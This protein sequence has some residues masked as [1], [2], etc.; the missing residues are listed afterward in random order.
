M[1]KIVSQNPG[2]TEVQ[3]PLIAG[4]S[5]GLSKISEILNLK[6]A[7]FTDLKLTPVPI[8]EADKNRIYEAPQN[9]LWLNNPPIIVKKNHNIITPSSDS[10]EIDYVG[11]SISFNKNLL[12]SDNIT[13]TGSYIV[14]DS[15]ALDTITKTLSTLQVN[16]ERYKGSFDQLSDLQ[17]QYPVGA[18]GDIALVVSPNFEIFGWNNTE[19]KWETTQSIEDLSNYYTKPEADALYNKKEPTINPKGSAT[20][21]DNFYYGGRKTWQN[22]NEKV[23]NTQL[24]GLNKLSTSEITENDT[25]LQALGKLQAQTKVVENKH[26][27]SGNSEPTTSTVGTIGQRYVNTSNGDSFRCISINGSQYKWVKEMSI[28][29]YDINNNGIVD[30][31][32]KL[33]GKTPEYYS[34]ICNTNFVINGGFQIWQRGSNFTNAISKYTADRWYD[35]DSSPNVEKIETVYGNGIRITKNA[36]SSR[37]LLLQ[38]FDDDLTKFL[39]GK[40]VTLSFWVKASNSGNITVRVGNNKEDFTVNTSWQKIIKKATF[41]TSTLS[42]LYEK[43]VSFFSGDTN[44][45]EITQVKL[46][47][48]D[49]ATPF[50]EKQYT[51]ELLNCQRY[52]YQSWGNEI[53]STD[54]IVSTAMS[55]G[56]ATGTSYPVEMIKV[57]Q[58]TLY[59]PVTKSSE[60]IANWDNDSNVQAETA[61]GGK[62]SFILSSKASG[63]TKNNFYYF[64]YKADAEFY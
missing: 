50:I 54:S 20:T 18:S 15:T 8:S 34:S 37:T 48:G 28:D 16:A 38:I 46:E 60:N 26:Y 41:T 58:I 11:G 19:M 29:I 64:H 40:A 31:A 47:L 51:E 1:A 62:K 57:P 61:Y 10:F 44:A 36:S 27:I 30:N 52:Y 17:S 13:V 9:R 21:D 5:E 45:L 6:T 32:E 53:T 49:Y 23:R 35:R 42:A 63:F 33:G 22:V 56:K 14:S 4:L 25:I 39:S 24:N 2:S 55:V 12:D 3:S 43:G 59:N 7:T